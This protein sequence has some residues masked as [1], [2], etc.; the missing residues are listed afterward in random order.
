[1]DNLK[2]IFF[3]AD[4]T[5]V[6]H[7]ECERQALAYVFDNIGV[8]C[9]S[10]YQDVFR[11]IEQT[12]WDTESYDGIHVPRE[13]VFTYRFKVL[14][15]KLSINYDDCTKAN[16]FFK[17][18]LADSAA[19]NVNAVEVVEYLYSKGYLLCV[20]TNG[21]IKLQ[22]PRVI[23]S[24]IGE[25]ITHIMVSE[26]VGAHKPNP[27]IFTSLLNRIQLNPDNVIMVG[28]SIKNDIQG[29]KNAGIK[30][31]W[32]NPEHTKN[33]TDLLPDYE[34]ASLLELKEMC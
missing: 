16:D 7:K 20:V 23:N 22:K 11:H 10:E 17:I 12:I 19:L 5:L 31:V 2:A 6:N 32:Y 4:G 13:N 27:L 33:R 9:K 28:D 30:S 14:F 34:I 15:E 29:A 21:L 24:K 26:E 18:G 8:S 25:Y 1:M 3:D